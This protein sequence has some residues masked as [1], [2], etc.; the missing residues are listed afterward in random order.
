MQKFQNVHIRFDICSPHGVE[1]VNFHGKLHQQ[2]V[3]VFLIFHMHV[4]G[5]VCCPSHQLQSFE[6]T[7]DAKQMNLQ[8]RNKRGI[9]QKHIYL[10][11]E[12]RDY[13]DIYLFDKFVYQLV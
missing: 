3:Q 10:Y 6:A 8:V 13:L 1:H 5:E 7:G 9:Q 4:V 2:I 12:G 11:I